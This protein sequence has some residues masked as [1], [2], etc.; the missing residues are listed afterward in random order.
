MSDYQFGGHEE[1]K[2]QA[3][4][5]RAGPTGDF[6]RRK[7]ALINLYDKPLRT[8]PSVC[9]HHG[10]SPR[11]GVSR[12]CS[13]ALILAVTLACFWAYDAIAH[14]EPAYVPLRAHPLEY[15]DE[16][17]STPSAIAPDMSSDAVRYANADVPAEL[18]RSQHKPE[19]QKAKHAAAPHRKKKAPVIATRPPPEPAMRAY[20][21]G[22]RAFQVPFGGF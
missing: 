1:P 21:W 4:V 14:R 13:C 22:P 15:R 11:D 8:R 7:P 5:A 3:Q 6:M 20:A 17:P 19:P 16:R 18:Q 12:L 2:R 9:W 10:M